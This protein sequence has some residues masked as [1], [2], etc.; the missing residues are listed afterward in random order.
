MKFYQWLK[1]ASQK[2]PEPEEQQ[3]EVVKETTRY[4]IIK[5]KA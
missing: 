3:N 1:Q 4:L 5:S 2:R